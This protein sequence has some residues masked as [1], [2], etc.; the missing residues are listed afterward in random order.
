MHGLDITEA[1]KILSLT[2]TLFYTGL[3]AKQEKITR[4]MSNE[5]LEQYIEEDGEIEEITQ[6]LINEYT[7]FMKS[8]NGKK[9]KKAKI[10]EV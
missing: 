4:E 9:K 5:L 7:A 3:L 1:G 10:V 6:F 2:D 8:P